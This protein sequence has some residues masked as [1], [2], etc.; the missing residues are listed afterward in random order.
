MTF[1]KNSS[2]TKFVPY[3]YFKAKNEVKLEQIFSFFRSKT[4]FPIF[5]KKYK[6]ISN[7]EFYFWQL[8]F[9]VK[10]RFM[11]T[12]KKKKFIFKVPVIFENENSPI[13]WN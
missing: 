11:P 3:F 4:V 6:T 10:G 1:L 2:E 8:V 12:L 9:D 13:F 7:F 5:E